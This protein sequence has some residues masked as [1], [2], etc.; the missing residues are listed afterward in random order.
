MRGNALADSALQ[1]NDLEALLALDEQVF[2]MSRP[3]WIGTLLG[4]PT[5]EFHGRRRD[6][7]LVSSV[8]LRTRKQG[9]ICLDTVN[10]CEFSELQPLLEDVSGGLMDRRVECFART[11]SPL[12]GFLLDRGF[13]VPEFFE[14]IGPLVEW[15]RGPVGPIGDSPRVQ[16]LAWF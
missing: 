2:G 15:R 7:D 5:T 13:A 4:Q 16:S 1:S 11:D 8:C 9:A 10:A 14:A 12:H 3:D 6:G